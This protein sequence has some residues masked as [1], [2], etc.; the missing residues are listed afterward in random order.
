M[1]EEQTQPAD[2]IDKEDRQWAV[3]GHLSAFAGFI[4]PLGNVIA[5]LIVWQI[6]KEL[7]FASDQ[8]KEALN[9]QITMLL[10]FI[11]CMI[12]M[13]VVI[14][15]FLMPIVGLIAIGFPIYAAIKAN[16]GEQFR[17]PYIL[18]LVN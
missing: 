4:I 7:P 5:P 12:L 2:S 6:K 14:G 18:R 3:I 17:Y 16:E 11:A 1:A 15:V 9:F 10:A 13:V 8:A